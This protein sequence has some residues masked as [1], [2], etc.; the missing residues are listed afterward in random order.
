MSAR[1]YGRLW[2][3]G[4]EWQLEAEP[5]LI[6]KAKRIF[7][8]VRQ[9][10]GRRLSLRHNPEICR[11][12]SWFLDRY[13]LDVENG[14]VLQESSRRHHDSIARLEQL[15]DPSYK[16]APT[17][18]AVPLREYQNR[19]AELYL[20][21]G[22]L[23]LADDVGLGK[24]AVAIASFANP[25]TLPAVVVTMTF[26]PRQWER[27]IRRFAPNL[28][29]HVV[30]KTVPYD[31][32]FL[33][34]GPDVIIMNYHKLSGWS[35]VLAEYAR[36]IVFDE[37]QELRS[38]P[39]TAKYQG[40]ATIAASCGHRLGLSATPIYNYGGEIWNIA[41]IL[42]PDCLGSQEEFHREWCM[43]SYGDKP[44]IA[45]PAALGSYLRDNFIMLRRTRRDVGR[46]LP[47]LV[48]VQ[49]A[50]DSDTREL[51]KIQSTAGDLARI[52]LGRVHAEREERWRAGG[53]FDM[54]MRQATG[55]AKAPFVA[56]FVRM[57]AGAGEKVLLFGWHRAVYEIWREKLADLNPVLFTGTE[58]AAEKERSR[59]AFVDGDSQVM[60]MS[61]R[62]GA[63]LDGLQRVCRV[64]VFG[65]LDWSPGVHDQCIGRLHRDGQ[66]ESVTA[67]YLVAEDGSDPVVA[68]VLGLKREQAEGIRNPDAAVIEKYQASEG[69]MKML[70]ENFLKNAPVGKGGKK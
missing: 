24:T 21:S 39:G 52:I 31:L 43:S 50:I 53:E 34:R 6:I 12:L 59:T 27:E 16:P 68:D 5:H 51:H 66:E 25:A 38:G 69:H 9:S 36:S 67:Y 57:L 60:C 14:D 10:G 33:G 22:S 44:R 2:L 45:D 64:V 49:H 65:E 30:K 37:I 23:L 17:K 7:P 4:N 55:L 62:S 40:A 15:I 63:G 26:L 20:T 32:K 3:D 42:R 19:A 58:T 11:D 70:A 8:R 35:G 46:E 47:D 1:T 54:L 61:L 48:K 41:N 28:L 29:V 56:D 13:P 18:L